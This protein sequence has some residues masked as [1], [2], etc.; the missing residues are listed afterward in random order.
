MQQ[1]KAFKF[2]LDPTEEQCILLNKT[3][4]CVRFVW[5]QLV[6]DFNNW[7]PA[8]EHIKVTEKTL[9][10]NPEY[11]WLNEVSAASLQQKRRDFDETKHQYF[12]KQ[13]KKK[14][15]MC[16]MMTTSNAPSA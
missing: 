12:N 14:T 13:R 11:S 9:K 6:E 8:I 5:N 4:G 1:L 10:D 16:L 2:K 3:F 7:N 15:T